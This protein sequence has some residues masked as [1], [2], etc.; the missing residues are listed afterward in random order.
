MQSAITYDSL[1]GESVANA[2]GFSYS[3]NLITKSL[4]LPNGKTAMAYGEISI[5]S[6]GDIT[7]PNGSILVV[8]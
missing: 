3:S 2:E 4:I 7:V 6:T 1:T 5:S 8:L